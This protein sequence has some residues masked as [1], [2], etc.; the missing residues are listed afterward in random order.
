MAPTL[1]EKTE[2]NEQLQQAQRDIV[3][4][5]FSALTSTQ[6]YPPIASSFLDGQTA[7]DGLSLVEH[8]KLL[9]DRLGDWTVPEQNRVAVEEIPDILL[10]LFGRLRI[11][12]VTNFRSLLQGYEGST[13]IENQKIALEGIKACGKPKQ[14]FSSKVDAPFELFGVRWDGVEQSVGGD[15]ASCESDTPSSPGE[16]ASANSAGG[17]TNS[18]PTVSAETEPDEQSKHPK[19]FPFVHEIAKHLHTH[20]GSTDSVNPRQHNM[21]AP[22]SGTF[23]KL[24][25]MPS[26]TP[27]RTIAV[28]EFDPE[29]AYRHILVDITA[30]TG[31]P[32]KVYQAVGGGG[33][34]WY[35]IVGKVI[36]KDVVVGVST[37][38]VYTLPDL[39]EPD[40]GQKKDDKDQ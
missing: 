13:S 18:S 14:F 17:E 8:I 5:A 23:A 3:N 28:E 12:S 35:W 10:A 16:F 19:S 33:Q 24:I 31:C 11:D 9:R 25:H 29:G 30:A 7:Q 38:A 4:E 2:K 40:G 22:T 34:V 26:N 36:G 21:H 15:E 20:K 27:V 39:D 1:S 37:F 6:S 32:A